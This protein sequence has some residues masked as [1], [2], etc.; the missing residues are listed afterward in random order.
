VTAPSSIS[1][2]TAASLV[3]ERELVVVNPATLEV[4]GSVARSG[5]DELDAT[6]SAALRAQDGFARAPLRSRR[7]LLQ[8]FGEAILDAAPEIAATVT[9]ETGKPLL[10]SVTADVMVGL[11]NV[12]WLARHFE[13]ILR[14][15]RVPFPQPYFK[16]KRARLVYEPRGVV[17]IV[18]PWNFPFGI[19][20]TQTASALAA[21]NGVVLKPSELAPLSGAWVEEIA[22]RAGAPEGL[23]GVVH[24]EGAVAGDALVGH[25]GVAA[26]VFTG[27]T[28]AGRA[29]ALRAAE[30]L[31]PV[32]LE[33]G[34]KDAMLVLADADLDRAVEGALWGSFTNCGQV[35]SGIERILVADE[36]YEAFVAGLTERV[37]TLRP[38]RGEDPDVDLG[39]LIT[40]AQRSRVEG[41]VADATE[42]G[43]EVLTGGVRPDVPLPG[44]FYEPTVLASVSTSARVADEEVFGPVVSVARFGNEADA[45]RMA[46][47][48]R[49]GLGMSVWTR[50]VARARQLAGRLRAGSVWVNDAAYSYGACQAPWGGT[51]DSG[52]GRTHSK[53]GLYALTNVKYADTDRGLLRPA[54]WYPYAD[55]P[56]RGFLTAMQVLHARRITDRVRAAVDGRSG[57]AAVARRMRGR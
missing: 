10:E 30:R 27:S 38:G 7:Q 19:A 1:P 11:E 51:K 18:S 23:V 22:R 4:V 13:P 25:R 17:G 8:R 5:A 53:H 41:L 49:F 12:H 26:I 34:G 57:L 42:Q 46:N 48:S 33:L 3:E 20:M 36:V 32:T 29:V 37:R 43:A 9:A 24:G 47:D 31:C 28:R 50:D 44:W 39:P 56:T 14:P 40:E 16:L 52:Y 55:A 45:I 2:V 6:V 21:G 54:W 35:C 15:E